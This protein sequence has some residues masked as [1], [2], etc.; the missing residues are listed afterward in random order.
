MRL[1]RS[2]LWIADVRSGLTPG[3]ASPAIVASATA[4]ADARKGKAAL[5][6]PRPDGA[7]RMA[8]PA[9]WRGLPAGWT[10][11]N[12]GSALAITAIG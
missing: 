6:L 9:A 11:P 12:G 2:S 1:A 8:A 3:G 4:A 5:T 7:A 10:L